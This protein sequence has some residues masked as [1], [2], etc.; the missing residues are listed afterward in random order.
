MMGSLD[1]NSYLDVETK[2]KGEV[3]LNA[4]AT[5]SSSAIAYIGVKRMVD[6]EQSR[7]L[8]TDTKLAATK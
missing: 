7:L 8:R 4:L 3:S 6:D 1:G 5:M 2:K